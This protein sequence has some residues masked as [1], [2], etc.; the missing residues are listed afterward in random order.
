M[1]IEVEIINTLNN[2]DA[3]NDVIRSNLRKLSEH[4]RGDNRKLI[5]IVSQMIDIFSLPL[6]YSEEIKID[7][8][9]QISERNYDLL[10]MI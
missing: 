6:K 5:Y 10:D 1:K 3:S 4:R 8:F 2:L 7:K 9:V